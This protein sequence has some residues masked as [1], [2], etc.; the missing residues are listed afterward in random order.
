MNDRI[1]H[2]SIRITSSTRI[3]A[4]G[5]HPAELGFSY[6]FDGVFITFTFHNTPVWSV[7]DLDNKTRYGEIAEK[8]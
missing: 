8:T 3:L 6:S 5:L 4:G 1:P 7:Y 2:Y